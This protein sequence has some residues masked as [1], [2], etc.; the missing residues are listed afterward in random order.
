MVMATATAVSA[1]VPR[2]RGDNFIGCYH[3]KIGTIGLIS[4]CNPQ[5][6]MMTPTL[7]LRR[8]LGLVLVA[9]AL[10]SSQNSSSVSGIETVT[11][12]DFTI[13]KV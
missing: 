9:K 6:K 12:D 13:T 2:N 3:G 4:Q 11:D 1:I 10:D 5:K 8:R 7:P